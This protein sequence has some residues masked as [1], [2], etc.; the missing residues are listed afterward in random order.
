MYRQLVSSYE[1]VLPTDQPLQAV[2]VSSTPYFIP[3]TIMRTFFVLSVLFLSAYAGGI[4]DFS[5]LGFRGPAYQRFID[6]LP[7][8]KEVYWVAPSC[9]GFREGLELWARYGAQ[10]APLTPRYQ[11]YENKISLAVWR[12][13]LPNRVENTSS[14][15]LEA[16]VALPGGLYKTIDTSKTF[17]LRA[18]PDSLSPVIKPVSFTDG[19]LVLNAENTTGDI[20][21]EVSYLVG[22]RRETVSSQFSNVNGEFK[23][24]RFGTTPDPTWTNF[25]VRVSVSAPGYSNLAIFWSSAH[26]SCNPTCK[27]V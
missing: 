27:D 10:R 20:N 15:V 11:T 3:R 12:M 25:E 4:C 23:F 26:V 21:V 7:A 22:L 9:A 8:G 5:A 24:D 18:L 6:A 2:R 13:S 19:A 14:I 16:R 1:P 17:S